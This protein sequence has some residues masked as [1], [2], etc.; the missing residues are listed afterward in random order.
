MKIYYILTITVLFFIALSTSA[1]A[2][3]MSYEQRKAY[4]GLYQYVNHTTLQIAAPPNDTILYAII[5]QAR[6]ALKPKAKDVFFNNANAPVIVLRDA[7]GA[8]SG[9]TTNKD[10][11]KLIGRNV[12]FPAKMWYPRMVADPQN[13]VYNYTKPKQLNAGLATADLAGSGLDPELLATMMHKIVA[14][15]YPNVH[16]VLIIKNNKLV[17]EEIHTY[18]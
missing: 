18:M 5:N 4:E 2:Q 12:H 8:I 17:F 15:Q 1:V 14:G 16:S 11:F 6:Y 10:T 7:K 13:F 3:K 9:Y